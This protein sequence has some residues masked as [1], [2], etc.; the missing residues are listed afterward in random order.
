MSG[1]SIGIVVDG[2]LNMKGTA[3]DDFKDSEDENTKMSQWMSVENPLFKNW[4][5]KRDSVSNKL[6]NK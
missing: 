3:Q 6:E 4:M 1:N 5:V 2:T